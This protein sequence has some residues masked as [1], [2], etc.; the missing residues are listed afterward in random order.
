[1]SCIDSVRQVT[2]PAVRPSEQNDRQTRPRT[3]DVAQT[4]REDSSQAQE[5]GKQTPLPPLPVLQQH[6]VGRMLH[7]RR[8]RKKGGLVGMKTWNIFNSG[9]INKTRIS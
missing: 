9:F 2:W 6:L 3:A 5:M 8:V 7:L 1:M 4:F